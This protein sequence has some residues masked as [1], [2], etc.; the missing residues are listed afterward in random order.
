MNSFNVEINALAAFDAIRRN[1]SVSLAAAE[2]GL[3]QPTLSNRLRRLR[4]VLGDPLFVRTAEGM[5][6]TPFADEFGRYVTEA[7]TL[8]D[9]GMRT[10]RTFDPSEAE[11]TFTIIMTDIAEAVVLPPL[12]ESTK[13][14][15]P[16]MRFRT[17]RL[18]VDDTLVALQSGDVDLA[19]GFIPQLTTGIYQN[20]LFE[21][22]YIC[23]AS[24]GH[25]TLGDRISRKEF[26][27]AR[28]AVADARGT[29]HHVVEKTLDREGLREQINIRVPSFLS[30]PL[31]V[32]A[33][34]M[35]ATVPRPLELIMGGAT[36]LKRLRHPFDLPKIEIKQ[37]WHERFNND[38]ANKWLR[39]LLREVFVSIDWGE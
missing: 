27:S 34:D 2:L 3:S 35:I 14:C 28:H 7:L 10:R 33:S 26:L 17:L 12:L 23:I 22:E 36:R 24:A 8:I 25:P 19:I 20:L 37:F 18:T 1:R 39:T 6:P 9:Q 38:P 31:I 15:A 13:H 21:T 29:G 30:L 11:R 16:G 5:M 32:A 4:S